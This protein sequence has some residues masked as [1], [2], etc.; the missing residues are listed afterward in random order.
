MDLYNIN[1]L[2]KNLLMWSNFVSANETEVDTPDD[3]YIE[4]VS[5]S[6]L[7]M[8]RLIIG[9]E[10]WQSAM[11]NYLKNNQ[12]E[13]TVPDDMYAEI[14]KFSSVELN[15]PPGISLQQVF[16][17]WFSRAETDL[18]NV[19]RQYSQ[20]R[21]TVSQNTTN[22]PARFIPY[23]YAYYSA[24]FDH[25][26]PIQWL[27]TSNETI[28]TNVSDNQWIIFNK[29]QFG[30]YRVNYDDRNWRMIIQALQNNFSSVDPLNRVQLLDDAHYLFNQQRLKIELFLDLL[31]FVHNETDSVVWYKAIRILQDMKYWG[32][33]LYKEFVETLTAQSI[34]RMGSRSIPEYTSHLDSYVHA[35]I[36][37]LSCWA[38]NRFCRN[39]AKENLAQ[40]IRTSPSSIPDDWSLVVFCYGLYE[41][42]DA[43][44]DRVIKNYL[45]TR[46]RQEEDLYVVGFSCAGSTDRLKRALETILEK[47]KFN[48]HPL[49]WTFA[50]ILSYH[51][52]SD[53]TIKIDGQLE[54]LLTLLGTDQQLVQMIGP[55]LINLLPL[56]MRDMI[57]SEEQR[58]DLQQMI[59]RFNASILVS[60]ADNVPYNSHIHLHLAKYLGKTHE[61]LQKLPEKNFYH[62]RGQNQF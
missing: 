60:P 4:L 8:V 35:N 54:N 30:L 41:S 20:N 27:T 32:Q 25:I 48:P 51:T 36:A 1:S 39:Y 31:S 50:Q 55:E 34:Q 21:I 44:F 61:E 58:T 2:Q 11:R 45:Q 53:S 56:Q 49:R 9:D 47:H 13:S 42:N 17:S 6:V 7:N 33:P 10:N 12:F 24:H 40:A 19:D 46:N 26:R 52:D 14:E 23:N 59:Q 16:E 62:P 29:R 15:L 5:G 37:R 22:G 57:D 28:A 38:G 18:L 43:D 3:Y